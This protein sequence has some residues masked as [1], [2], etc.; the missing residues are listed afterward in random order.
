MRGQINWGLADL[1]FHPEESNAGA[2]TR[3]GVIAADRRVASSQDVPRLAEPLCLP[4]MVDARGP[5]GPLD[6]GL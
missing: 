1:G 2:R 6:R 3:R 5:L 4:L